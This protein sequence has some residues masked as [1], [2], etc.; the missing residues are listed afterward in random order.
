MSILRVIGSGIGCAVFAGLGAFVGS[1]LGD[2]KGGGSKDAAVG[3]AILGSAVGALLVGALA[4]TGSDSS[5]AAEQKRLLERIAGALGETPSISIPGSTASTGPYRL[6]KQDPS[7]GWAPA[8][9]GWVNGGD[10]LMNLIMRNPS[11]K[12]AAYDS[13]MNWF[14]IPLNPAGY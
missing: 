11:A 4:G 1:E 7:G 5:E 14:E 6:Y 10:D 2:K 13:Q 9:A 12:Y 3:G 8:S